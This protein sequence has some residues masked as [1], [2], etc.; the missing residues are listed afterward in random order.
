MA[1][2]Q[3]Q[4]C[5]SNTTLTIAAGQVIKVDGGSLDVN[6][7]VL[8]ANGGTGAQQIFFTSIKDD[9]LGGDTNNDSNATTPA[10]GDWGDIQIDS[11]G[12]A[13]INHVVLRY[14]GNG[15]QEIFVNGGAMTLTKSVLTN[16]SSKG[17]YS[18]TST[19]VQVVNNLIYSNAADGI[20]LGSGSLSAFNN[21]IDSNN[22][23]VEADGGTLTLTNNLITNST[24]SGVF[25]SNSPTVT[26]NFNDVFNSGN[27]NYNGLSNPTGANGNVSVNPLYVN[28]GQQNYQLSGSSP[29][30]GVGMSTG[31][32]STDIVDASR[33]NPPTLGAY[34]YL[35]PSPT[36]IGISPSSDGTTGGT[37]VTITGSHLGTAATV[38]VSFGGNAASITSDNGST[39]VV[40]SPAGPTGPVAVTVTTAGG[41]TTAAQQF[42]YVSSP[43]ISSVTPIV[44]PV[45]G[46]VTVTITGANLGSVATATVSFGGNIVSPISDNGSTLVINSPAGVAGPGIR[47]RERTAAATATAVAAVHLFRRTEH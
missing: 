40:S 42:T 45:F 20:Q 46:G 32:P 6:G 39:L 8:T 19:G 29:V 4:C 28:A 18:Q 24:D 21:T 15:G 34:E 30:I 12:A 17:I 22:R 26:L 3:H 16:S 37:A 27:R 47:N 25:V 33:H 14:G 38:T 36:V 10:R 43:S 23:G 31:A 11:G 13:T 7:G 1:G 9:T 41:M 35:P 44:G 5:R 2:R